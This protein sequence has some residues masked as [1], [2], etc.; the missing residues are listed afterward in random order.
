MPDLPLYG[1]G[2]DLGGSDSG[3]SDSFDPFAYYNDPN[4]GLGYG[5]GGD[6]SSY[7]YDLGSSSTYQ[8]ASQYQGGYQYPQTVAAP[9]FMDQYGAGIIGAAGQLGGAL[10]QSNAANN[11]AQTQLQGTEQGIQFAK[12]QEAAR[13]QRW[14]DATNAWAANRAAALS[15]YGLQ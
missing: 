5:F 11:A 1:Y 4:A 7:G 6:G 15:Y 12:E 10:I 3:G 2:Y 9:S 14:N 13:Q 8:P